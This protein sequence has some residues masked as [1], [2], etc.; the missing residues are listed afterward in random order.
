MSCG[1]G[2]TAWAERGRS[3]IAA[4]SHW[5]V[6]VIML[7]LVNQNALRYGEKYDALRTTIRTAVPTNQSYLSCT[8]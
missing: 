4:R 2:G 6:L 5:G 3:N 8:I 1:F 7:V